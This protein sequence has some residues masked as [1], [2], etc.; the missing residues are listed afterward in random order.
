[1]SSCVRGGG[2]D[3]G[4]V[5]Q[6]VFRERDYLQLRAPFPDGAGVAHGEDIPGIVGTCGGYGINH[7]ERGYGYGYGNCTG[8]AGIQRA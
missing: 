1:M 5:Q 4:A 3:V 6:C 2:G 8:V 7:L